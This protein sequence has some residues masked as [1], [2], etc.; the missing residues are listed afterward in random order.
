[1]STTTKHPELKTRGDLKAI[2]ATLKGYNNL[3]EPQKCL[4][5][6]SVAQGDIILQSAKSWVNPKDFEKIESAARKAN[7]AAK[8]A[9]L[10]PYTKCVP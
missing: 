8:Q 9:G 6:E 2:G 5:D 3:T 4:F 10:P 1:M 7:D